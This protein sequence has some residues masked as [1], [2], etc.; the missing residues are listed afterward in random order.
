MYCVLV[1][2]RK[3]F[4]KATAREIE[5][6]KTD[7]A[8]ICPETMFLWFPPVSGRE[9]TP[10]LDYILFYLVKIFC[11]GAMSCLRR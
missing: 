4:P 3:N 2:C 1:P 9:Q 7:I 11:L 8:N 5:D 6:S 10:F